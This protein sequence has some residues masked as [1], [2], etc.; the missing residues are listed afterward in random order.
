MLGLESDKLN[1]TMLTLQDVIQP[2]LQEA[3][4]KQWAEQIKRS[5]VPVSLSMALVAYMA[6]EYV[7]AWYW[8]VWLAL[9]VATQGLRLYAFT[10]LPDRTHIPV[11]KRIDTAVA[12]NLGGTLL[13]S[14]SLLWFPLFTPF[15]AA[16]QSMLFIGMGVA[17]VMGAAGFPPWARA[18]VFFGLIPI[19][20]LWAWSGLFGDGGRP[21]L[22]LAI[23]GVGYCTTVF[24]LAS[25]TFRLY[26]ESFETRKQL[27]VALEKAEAAGRAKTRFLASAS[28]DLRQPIHALALFSAA[29][30][31]RK[32]D[33]NTSNIVSN[34]NASIEALSYELDG[35][36]D[37]SKLDAGIVTVTRSNFCLASVMRRLQGE[38][39][40]LAE[41]RSIT[42]NLDCP[43][44]AVVNS[45]GTL[46]ERVLRNLI[47]NAIHHN[48]HC[49]VLLRLVRG[50]GGW[51]LAL[52]DTGRG[53]DPSEHENI[54]EEFYQL[55]NLERDRNKGL[56]LGL[57]IVRRLSQ[58][59][60]IHMEFDS[61]LG[62][63]TTFEFKIPE[64]I[65][66]QN[67]EVEIASTSGSLE[68]LVILVVDDELSVREGMR[69]ILE[70]LGC[71]VT[72]TESTDTAISA[73]SAE[74]P[75][76]V[77]AD[78]RLRNQDN[79]LIAIERLRSLYPGLPAII[80]SG[81]T[82]PERLLA[83]S[84]ANIP[85]LVKPVLVGPLK[86]AILQNC[87]PPTP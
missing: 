75:D 42:I 18:H 35:L 84:E 69:S 78:L 57:S 80:I 65:P 5:T 63:G 86:D 29:L 14:V 37:I 53:I 49:V 83:V 2:D 23:I 46:L 66:Q 28:H 8:G 87:Y 56:G 44:R 16:M 51:H 6:A 31:A 43:D 34:I 20:S 85:V 22:F 52:S 61:A 19:F 76:I 1:E 59:L 25:Q 38:Y 82:A 77:L 70:S 41:N 73:A 81:D 24:R 11:E 48:T 26:R 47:V 58:L 21:A 71:K 79:G 67:E 40:P 32:L 74:K 13:H 45:D 3:L 10:R 15:Q 50:E 4:L 54:F 39:S 64:R 27:E 60:D 72:T 62:R 68:S 36:L 9:V 33:D 17:S 30:T 55:E 7:S 12:I